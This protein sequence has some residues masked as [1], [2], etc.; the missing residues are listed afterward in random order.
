MPGK[1]EID[2]VNGPLAGKI[3]KFTIPF[4]ISSML[5]IFYNA[6]DMIV[7]GRFSGS[8]ALAA[9]SSTGSL[10]HLFINVFMGLSVG[11]SI[12][13]SQYIGSRDEK[14]VYETIHTSIAMSL[15]F[16]VFL[17]AASF[18]FVTPILRAM[19]TPDDVMPLS[20]VYLRIYFLGS[21]ANLLYNYGSAVLRTSGDTKRPLYF[22]TV[23]G[24]VNIILNLVLVICFGLGVVGVAAATVV[25]QYISAALVAATLMRSSGS[26][27]LI[28]SKIRIYPKKLVQLLRLGIPA[29]MQGAFFSLSN[30]LIQSSVNSFG[31]LAIAGSGASSNIESFTYCAMSAIGQ[32]ALVFTGQNVGA[33][34]P[35][36]VSRT[37]L[38]CIMMVIVSWS[39]LASITML[40]RTQLMSVFL[41]DDPKAAAYGIRRL[42][43]IICTYFLCGIFEIS[44]GVF[45]GMGKSMFPSAASLIGVCGLRMLWVFTVFARVHTF[46][47]LFLSYPLSWLLTDVFMYVI[48]IFEFRSMKKKAQD[49]A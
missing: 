40:F 26:C 14:S 47:C 21:P 9:V 2:M 44:V 11:T 18:F 13:L 35:E 30:M 16:G 8:K 32:S 37:H 41:P 28:P 20:A 43:I 29:S 31:S 45:R 25:S 12:A 19:G 5:Q 46:E 42:K 48:Y 24:I 27:K 36:R 49:C 6:A 4:V 1:H 15:L 23:S 22:L 10:T 7:V 38:L 3:I 33:K 34:K 17:T 39:L